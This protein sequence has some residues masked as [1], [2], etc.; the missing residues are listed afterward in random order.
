[1]PDEAGIAGARRPLKGRTVEVEGYTEDYLTGTRARHEGRL[2]D[3]IAA[4]ERV[5]QE[6]PCWV[7]AQGNV[8][9]AL[10]TMTRYQEAETHLYRVF[11]EI[12]RRGCPYPA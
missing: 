1:M 12:D 11:E 5:P 2:A 4:F 8:G 7:M 10:L 3:A 9:L 6:S